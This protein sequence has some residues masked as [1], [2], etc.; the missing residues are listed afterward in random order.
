MEIAQCQNSGYSLPE[1]KQN[2]AGIILSLARQ[3]CPDTS[4]YDA[5]E[6]IYR[7]NKKNHAGLIVA[8]PDQQRVQSLIENY[9]ARFYQDFYASAPA[10][11]K[12]TT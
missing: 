7:V 8:S 10:P 11:D 12:P 6:I 1:V 3:E 4:A 2:Y 5:P 9:T